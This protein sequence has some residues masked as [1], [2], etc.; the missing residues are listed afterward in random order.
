MVKHLIASLVC[1]LP[2]TGNATNQWFE[3][4]TSLTSAHQKLLEDNLEGTFDAI[5]EVWQQN[6]SKYVSDH[7]DQLFL[8]SI[9]KDC[10]RS[11]N[12]EG[13]PDWLD[14]V[15]IR[16]QMI[17]S[18][19]RN[20][21]S[22][23]IDVLSNKDVES[24]ELDRWG[25]QNISNESTFEKLSSETSEQSIYQKRYSLNTRLTSGLYLLKIK[26]VNE[27]AWVTWA[28]MAEPQA[29]QVVR[30]QSKDNWKVE[31]TSLLNKHC[32]LPVLNISLF[33]Y[34]DGKY[35]KVWTQDY[36]SDYPNSI[37]LRDLDPD[38]YVLA[39]SITHRRW[40]GAVS[41]E[42]QQVISKT[43]DISVD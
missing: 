36:E 11:L 23:I 33:D 7:L 39:V 5:V 3:Q 41:I 10:G 13:L 2:L 15:V 8:K 42:D 32:P 21:S 17:Q 14:E 26:P 22:V 29:K 40:Q 35:Q 24:I 19:G 30:W 37:P 38:R 4:Q 1:L 34:L 16:R 31:K 28:V 6:P 27:E 20:N 12:S 18:P 43:Y 9:E 25:E